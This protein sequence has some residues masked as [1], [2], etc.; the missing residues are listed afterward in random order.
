MRMRDLREKGMSTE[1]AARTSAAR[2]RCGVSHRTAD[3]RSHA[4][5]SLD[6]ENVGNDSALSRTIECKDE[7]DPRVA[8]SRD[9]R[10]WF[11]AT[12]FV[13]SSLRAA[14]SRSASRQAWEQWTTE[15][16]S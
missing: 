12:S 2:L 4:P 5:L 8:R 13:T 7:R 10:A 1:T 9:S 16:A 6:Q 11:R 14:A 3:D 15:P